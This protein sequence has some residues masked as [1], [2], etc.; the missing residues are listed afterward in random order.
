[1][2]KTAV[3]LSN[4]GITLFERQKYSDAII[5]FR[6][7]SSLI[8][9]VLHPTATL[10]TENELQTIIRN[11]TNCLIQSYDNDQG[12]P[13]KKKRTFRVRSL[14][15]CLSSTSEIL[16]AVH[17]FDATLVRMEDPTEVGGLA[18]RRAQAAAI[19]YNC[20]T[21]CH[22][23]PQL[24]GDSA[25]ED[26]LIFYD[27]A[28]ECFRG[29]YQVLRPLL[30]PVIASQTQRSELIGHEIHV[31]RALH[32]AV[33]LLPSLVQLCDQLGWAHEICRYGLD[34][35]SVCRTIRRLQFIPFWEYHATAPVA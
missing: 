27:Q 11:A 18:V 2:Y 31:S 22:C 12:P 14:S 23:L 25:A 29:A 9:T 8:R 7:A 26:C 20:G 17:E 16:H 28:W 35:E 5:I 34:F 15:D 33:L 3:A 21:A 24:L 4:M 13:K 6:E 1:V 19:L 30:Q 32:L 10:P